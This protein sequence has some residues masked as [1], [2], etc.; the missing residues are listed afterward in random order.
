M[1]P[2]G[3]CVYF[4][5]HVINLNPTTLHL[6]ATGSRRKSKTDQC[7]PRSHSKEGQGARLSLRRIGSLLER[8]RKILWHVEI[9]QQ[10][11]KMV[12]ASAAAAWERITMRLSGRQKFMSGETVVSFLPVFRS[13]PRFQGTVPEQKIKRKTATAHKCERAKRD[14][15]CL[16]EL[17]HI[18]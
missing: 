4:R 13:L 3:T 5:R 2:Q 16:A 10:H 11:S 1:P 18:M 6:S 8:P 9:K 14:P 15:R 12:R 7:W 17:V